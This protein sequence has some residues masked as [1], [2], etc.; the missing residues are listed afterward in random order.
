MMTRNEA[1][2]AELVRMAGAEPSCSSQ[3]RA[4][5][6]HR[7]VLGISRAR[8]RRLRRRPSRERIDLAQFISGKDD[9]EL[10]LRML[11]R[12]AA[13]DNEISRREHGRLRDVAERLGVEELTFQNLVAEALSRAGFRARSVARYRRVI[14]ATLLLASVL[15]WNQR[16]G[17]EES[18]DSNARNRVEFAD[19]LADIEVKAS[20]LARLEARKAA[21]SEVRKGVD[22]RLDTNLTR[23]FQEILDRKKNTFVFLY[24]Y[25][26]LV[27]NSS[28]RGKRK[29]RDFGATGTGF[30]VSPDGHVAT[31]KHV[32]EP[33][34]FDPELL[35]LVERGW[36][37]DAKSLVR[38]AWLAESRV[39]DDHRR[40]LSRTGFASS[41]G[42][43]EVVAVTPDAWR[44]RTSVVAPRRH[45][46]GPA[47]LAVLSIETNSPREC[48]PL[49]VDV[50]HLRPLDPV[51][52]CGFPL[53][54]AI[55]ESG[56]AR[57]APTI[58]SLRKVD[59]NLFVSA[60]VHPGNS[61][62]PILDERGRVI[63][64]TA[65]RWQDATLGSGILV[66]HL[67]PLLPSAAHW[68]ERAR[69]YAR[70]ARREAARCAL[71]LA[72]QRG[73]SPRQIQ[74]ISALLR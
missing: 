62:G 57:F 43:L 73:A 56:I 11:V 38:V 68:L 63:A 39:M 67:L 4:L 8:A 40:I 54:F 27:S 19:R 3:R 52:V 47:D 32:V 13:A 16:R 14:L 24:T 71:D 30:V 55:F 66:R 33:W 15:W 58:G 36:T 42:T 65:A 53:G 23:R 18:E 22:P 12:V 44:P 6:L 20:E 46:G 59:A 61:G 64:V 28:S 48:L 9:A 17:R 72:A 45:Q 29:T 41:R 35:A 50:S 70:N 26:T 60:S 7:K 10:I 69:F 1:I 34:K 5:E 25:G 51:M 31:N 49:E 74:K 2:Y 37:V 21:R